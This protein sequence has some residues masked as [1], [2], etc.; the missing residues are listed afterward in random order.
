MPS[1]WPYLASGEPEHEGGTPEFLATWQHSGVKR[2]KDFLHHLKQGRDVSPHTLRAYASDLNQFIEWITA[3]GVRELQ[4]VGHDEVKRY[5]ASLVTGGMARTSVARKAAAIRAFFRFLV[6]EGELD[7]DPS[8][9]VS[10][11]RVRRKL[12]RALDSDT[13]ARLLSAPVGTEFVPTRDRAILELLYSG[14]LR[15]S[16]AVGV[17]LAD[18]DLNQCVVR[19]MG[20]GRK[21]R[22]AI[23]GSHAKRA[24]KDYMDMRRRMVK[25]GHESWLFLNHRGTHLTSRS[26]H[27]VIARYLVTASLPEGTTPHTLRHTFATHLLER[28]ATLREVQEMLG[29]R[30]LSSTQIYTHVSPEH[31]RRVYESAHPRARSRSK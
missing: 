19:I 22:L 30:H 9:L 26:L 10:L 31:L 28:G 16:E 7:T 3:R 27:R 2:L 21:E 13:I 1:T 23:V 20:K 15:N 11:S 18:L 17:E 24:L 29:H 8:A 4:S 6:R 5:V 25:S 12:P 14:G